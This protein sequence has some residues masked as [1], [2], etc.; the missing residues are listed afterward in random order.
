MDNSIT[1]AKRNIETLLKADVIKIIV[2]DECSI[3]AWL[4]DLS[5]IVF[6]DRLKAIWLH[7]E[8]SRRN[9]HVILRSINKAIRERGYPF[10]AGYQMHKLYKV[11]EEDSNSRL[12]VPL[13]GEIKLG[14]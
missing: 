8:W 5:S 10:R 14:Y 2:E 11:D 1:D 4:D 3:E 7:P 13:G 9:D 6:S 12:N